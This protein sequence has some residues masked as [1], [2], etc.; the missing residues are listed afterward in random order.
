ML[1]LYLPAAHEG[2]IGLND[3]SKWAV[4]LPL[5]DS[6]RDDKPDGDQRVKAR[7]QHVPCF[8][9]MNRE[10]SQVR[11]QIMVALFAARR[12]LKPRAVCTGLQRRRRSVFQWEHCIVEG[13]VRPH[14]AR[15]P[16]PRISRGHHRL[17]AFQH[18][19][20]EHV[21]QH[22]P[23]C[24]LCV[25]KTCMFV[26]RVRNCG[27]VLTLC[28][29]RHL[30][31][32]HERALTTC[33]AQTSSVQTQFRSHPGRSTAASSVNSFAGGRAQNATGACLSRRLSSTS[34]SEA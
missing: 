3:H 6:Q 21:T 2:W 33:L 16:L 8:G 29:V 20:T 25:L 27:T 7:A 12:N 24:R 15:G 9:D 14:R 26:S 28:V 30:T 32:R 13:H 11:T 34:I 31:E 10:A 19:C 23:L 18:V 22:P 5:S 4:S 17:N 1:G